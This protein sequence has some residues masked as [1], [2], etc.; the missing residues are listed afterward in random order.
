MF[1]KKY[2][3][4]LLLL[5]FFLISFVYSVNSS[6]TD[7]DKNEQNL[8]SIIN[9]FSEKKLIKYAKSFL[10]TPHK[11]GGTDKKGID[12]S[13]FVQVCFKKFDI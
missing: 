5:G 13:G 4:N 11:M 2:T 8:T 3:F 6:I 9:G 10:G 12:C 7:V 1:K